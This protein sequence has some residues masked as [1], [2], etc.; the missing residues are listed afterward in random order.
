M[1][2]VLH[3]VAYFPPDRIGGVGEV[4]AN[5]HRALLGAGHVSTVLT[6]GRSRGEPHIVRIAA[7]PMRF[8]LACARSVA[9]ARRADVVHIHHGEGLGLLVMMKLLRVRTPILLT[10]HVGLRA[11]RQS[12]GAYRIDGREL[13][14]GGLAAHFYNTVV[15]RIREALDVMALAL[16][17]RVTFI[18]RSA[19]NDVLARAARASARVIY[20]GLHA[21]PATSGSVP[22]VELL[23]V[24][25]NST[26][27]RVEVLPVVLEAVR[28][29]RPT[30]RLRIVGFGPDENPE[31]AGLARE[32]DVLDAI[33]WEGRK[34]SD[35]LPP[36][37]RASQAL[38]VPSSYEGLPMVI[39]EAMQSGLPCV[40]THVSGHP[41][42][43]EDGVNGF[44]VP[45]DEPQAMAAAALRILEDPTLHATL[46]A[47]AKATVAERFG[48]ERQAREY[49]AVYAEMAAATAAPLPANVGGRA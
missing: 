31:L 23:F 39:L 35:E 16:A 10:L 29:R 1:T 45:L 18:S 12:L 19:A 14:R 20:N 47:R 37:Y 38:L 44:L 32:L 15:M 46:G 24:G 49:L 30:A 11:L 2:S 9:L 43:V 41:E 7:T 13:G 48:A 26:R 3:V 42:A 40:A 22:A 28:R 17:D 6:T 25:T 33:V 4:V 8:A 36:F 34:R 27:K 21:A 5:V